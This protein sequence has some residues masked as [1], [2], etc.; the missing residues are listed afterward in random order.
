MTNSIYFFHGTKN[1]TNYVEIHI[2]Y[3]KPLYLTPFKAISST[4]KILLRIRNLTI[5]TKSNLFQFTGSTELCQI[6][7]IL[8]VDFVSSA[9]STVSHLL[10]EKW[11]NNFMQS[12]LV[13]MAKNALYTIIC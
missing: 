7:L 2:E 9:N 3:I 4:C 11:G 5:K 12:I 10:E 8:F 6:E 1:E 13:S